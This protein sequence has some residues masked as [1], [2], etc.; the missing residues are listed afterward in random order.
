MN[1]RRLLL[2]IVVGGLNCLATTLLGA[3]PVT[4]KQIIGSWNCDSAVIDGRPLA[5]ETTRQLR[6]TLTPDRYK[7]QRGD[8]V[9]FDS[10]YT[11][12]TSKT[13]VQ[14][15]MIGTEGELKGKSAPGILK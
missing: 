5:E 4:A 10:T 15:D 9:L 6:L 11:L 1:P 14:I 13:P 3:E 8:Q 7:S 2:A 12:D